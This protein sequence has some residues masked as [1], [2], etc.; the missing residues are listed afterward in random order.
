M[1]LS[2]IDDEEM[3]SLFPLTVDEYVACSSIGFSFH[4]KDITFKF[5][6]CFY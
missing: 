4:F 1:Q 6:N 5:Y 2:L 3:F